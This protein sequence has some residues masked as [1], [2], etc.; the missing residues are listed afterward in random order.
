MKKSLWMVLAIAAMT[1]SSIALANQTITTTK[2]KEDMEATRTAAWGAKQD[3]LKQKETN[4]IEM[5]AKQEEMQ[6]QKCARIQER[7]SERT[8]KVNDVK[9]KHMS[10][11]KNMV[12]RISKFIERLSGQ[13]YDVSKIEAD[14]VVLNEKIQKFSTDYSAQTMKLGETK[15]FACDRS[16]DEFKSKLT[17]VRKMSELVRADAMEIRKYMQ[18]T[19][20]VDIQALRKQKIE[21]V[22]ST[23]VKTDEVETTETEVVE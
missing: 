6:A 12:N 11:Y 1:T 19:V 17:E 15:Q 16:D 22:E 10:V 14:L 5:Q 2:T 18:E 23:D 13:G 20:R 4:R 9:E 7:V 3:E 21:R 8:G